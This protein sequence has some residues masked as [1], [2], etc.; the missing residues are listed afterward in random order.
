[1]GCTLLMALAMSPLEAATLTGEIRDSD[2][3]KLVEARLYIRSSQGQWFF[4]RSA[5]S[6]GR[7]VE[8]RKERGPS[9][10]EMHTALSA[11]PFTVELPPGQYSLLAERGKEY[12]PLERKIDIGDS[13]ATVTL[14]IQR[15]VDMSQRGW[16][17]GDTHVHRTLDELP[18][19]M[20]A[21]DLNVAF[22]LTYWVTKSDTS[23]SQ[24]DK[25]Q[26]PV[27]PKLIEVSP[28][29]VIWP[30]NTEYEIFTVGERRHTLGA[31]FGL[32]HK[33]VLGRG[34]PPVRPIAEQVHREGGLLDLDKHNWPWSMMLIPVMK[35]DLFE[36]ANNHHWRTE[37]AFRTWGEQ[38]PDYMQL[39]RDPA[40]LDEKAWTEFGL[41][42]YYALLNCGFRLMPTAG[43]ATGVHP[44]PLG[45]NR[46]YVHCPRGFSYDEWL[47]EL[48]RG[49]SFVTTGPMID[50]MVN[51][52]VPQPSYQ[53]AAPEGDYFFFM[54]AASVHPRRLELIQEGRVIA[55]SLSD[56]TPSRGKFALTLGTRVVVSSST[57][58]AVRCFET[59]PSGRERFAHSAPIFID[60]ANKPLVPGKAEAEY[61]VSRVEAEI[62]RNIGVLS[63]E[64]LAEFQ[65]AL[66]SYRAIAEHS[67]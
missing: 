61:L 62:R 58:F 15:W 28:R 13:P 67:R 23:P 50:V 41:K 51:G 29:H 2:T 19:A 60:V 18:I 47:S 56:A 48:A 66:E 46:V 31:V 11:H 16:F 7:A 27:E 40:G 22:P 64:A 10:V 1:V 45:W 65:E 59:L 4:A 9:S 44:V 5:N 34:V 63:K 12:W 26:P 52:Q 49:R 57:W 8:Y 3:G 35:V 33:S 53:Q 55:Y 38:P 20:L 25:N 36:L 6:A 54:Q 30:L 14:E 17:S 43:T 39:A 37:F 42:N 24:G 21:E 32:G